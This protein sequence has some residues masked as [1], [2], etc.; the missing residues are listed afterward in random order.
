MVMKLE[1]TWENRFGALTMKTI[2]ADIAIDR[3]GGIKAKSPPSAGVRPGYYHAVM[4]LFRVPG[5]V[6][7]SGMPRIR[8]SLKAHKAG[9]AD[10]VSLSRGELYGDDGR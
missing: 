9:L 8:F 7:P 10:G 5:S 6:K 3:A 4:Q 2:E 1:T